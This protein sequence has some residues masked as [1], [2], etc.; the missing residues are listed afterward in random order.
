MFSLF[1]MKKMVSRSEEEFGWVGG[2]LRGERRVLC[3][4]IWV[5]FSTVYPRLLLLHLAFVE[6]NGNNN[7]VI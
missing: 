1:K 3:G 7:R 5:D 4:V 6:F 2:R